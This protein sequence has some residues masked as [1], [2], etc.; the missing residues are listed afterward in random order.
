M[1]S[2]AFWICGLL[3]LILGAS[4][5]SYNNR[6]RNA[7][8]YKYSPHKEDTMKVLVTSFQSRS[9]L[10]CSHKCLA[11]EQCNYRIFNID[12]KKCELL[13]SVSQEDL[14]ENEVLLKKQLV[15]TR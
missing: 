9:Q 4:Q 12:T 15:S 8:F 14:K 1:I 5:T 7:Y 11:E 6:Y 2:M 13:Q 10:A 3:H